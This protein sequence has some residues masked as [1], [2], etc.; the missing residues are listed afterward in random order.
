M[1]YH[2]DHL[3]L[4]TWF[5]KVFVT[6]DV[7]SCSPSNLWWPGCHGNIQISVDMKIKVSMATYPPVGVSNDKHSTPL[8]KL[9]LINPSLKLLP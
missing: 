6:T 7:H 5:L 8:I 2:N 3:N 4:V 9:C 1:S